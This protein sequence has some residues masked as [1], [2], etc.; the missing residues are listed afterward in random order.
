AHT[1]TTP[2][3]KKSFGSQQQKKDMLG[4]ALAHHLPYIATATTGYPLDIIAKVKKALTIKGPKYLQ[5]YTP[6][7]PGWGIEPKD[8]LLASQLAVQSGFYP[9]VEYIDGRLARAQKITR[10]VSVEEFLKF[11]KRFKHLFKGPEG[12]AEIAK[13][14]AMADEK[15]R[16]YG[17]VG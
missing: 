14:Q 7:V 9:I 5:I 13:I 10:R 16:K 1:T 8:T 6:C 11:Q 12:K 2:A 3:G 17:L 15:I 4:I